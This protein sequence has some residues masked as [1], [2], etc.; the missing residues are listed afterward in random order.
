M[1]S[2]NI[3]KTL[4]IE[5]LTFNILFPK[6]VDCIFFKIV[7]QHICFG[8]DRG[9]VI[10]GRETSSLEVTKIF[11]LLSLIQLKEKHNALFYQLW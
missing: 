8:N 1:M 2:S 10:V 3:H 9:H 7:E 5:G 6:L 11:P 4:P